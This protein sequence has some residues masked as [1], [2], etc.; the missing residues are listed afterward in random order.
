MSA[1]RLSRTASAHPK[2]VVTRP[3]ARR[4]RSFLAGFLPAAAQATTSLPA[5]AQSS[6]TSKSLTTL[7]EAN[8]RNLPEV[9]FSP[10]FPYAN[11]TPPLGQGPNKPP[12]DRKAKLGKTLRVLQERLP[13][14][15]QSPLPHEILAP[16][17]SLHLF[18]STHPH[19]P[20]VSGRMAYIAA[21]W[22][23][24][25]AW[26]RIPIIGD[27]QLEIMSERMVKEP[28]TRHGAVSEKLV[29]RWRTTG[30]GIGWRL[31]FRD[32]EQAA[33]EFW[34]LFIFE[35]DGEGRVLSHTIEHVQSEGDWDRGIGAKFV[36]LTDWL[37]GGMRGRE[38]CPAFEIHDD[39]RP[40]Q[41]RR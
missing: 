10:T 27:V 12:D 18:P 17:I 22:T 7:Q 13:T 8:T 4:S 25:V 40:A 21:L 39:K 2:N 31:P 1:P 36:G 37:L 33:K 3:A 34:G 41:R 24:P 9:W 15:L 28:G 5:K 19:L 35:F 11:T 32:A 38:G 26:N 16:N 29:V 23:A 14:L 20:A 6:S 30:K